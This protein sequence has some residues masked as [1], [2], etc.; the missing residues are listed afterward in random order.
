MTKHPPESWEAI[1]EELLEKKAKVTP[2]AKP[3]PKPEPKP[4]TEKSLDLDDI[5][6]DLVKKMAVNTDPNDEVARQRNIRTARKMAPGTRM[7]Q[8]YLNRAAKE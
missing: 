1:L 7:L 6:D 4:M 8:R 5:V 2:I 3:E